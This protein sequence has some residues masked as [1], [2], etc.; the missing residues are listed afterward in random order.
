MKQESKDLPFVVQI[1]TVVS[2]S[3]CHADDPG[4]IPGSEGFFL[5]FIFCCNMFPCS[6]PLTHT[7]SSRG[8]RSLPT[9]DTFVGRLGSRDVFMGDD[10]PA[11]FKISKPSLTD[12]FE[13]KGGGGVHVYRSVCR[14]DFG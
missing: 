5:F 8:T 14:S 6:S 3:A 13:G 10:K 7:H 9:P 11:P 12:T 2:I 4:S 1:S